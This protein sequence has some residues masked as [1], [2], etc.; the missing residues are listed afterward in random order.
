M[1]IVGSAGSGLGGAGDIGGA[2]GSF[3]SHTIDQSLRF[4]DGDS[5][6]LSRTPSGAGNQKVWTWSAWVKRANITSE[7]TLFGA[8]KGANDYV[9]IQFDANDTLNVT[10]KHVNATGGGLSSQT[11]RKIT[12]QVFRDVS[13]FYHL[14]VKF[15]AGNTNC[16]IYVNGTEVTSFSVNEEPQD[17][18]FEVNAAQ[19]HYIG[20]FQNSV[21]GLAVT[22]FDGYMA[23]INLIDGTALGPDSF[24]ETKDGVWIPKDASGLT[25]GTN[26]F[27]LTFEATGTATTTQD[28][29]AQTNIGDDQSG[30]G[31]NSAVSGLAA[32]D[33]VLDS[34]T[35]NFATMNPLHR[36]NGTT[37]SIT[38]SEGNLAS[39]FAGNHTTM[40]H[41]ATMALPTT[42][43]WY[44]EQTF[45]G[46]LTNGSRAAICGIWN[47][48]AQD[49]GSNNRLTVT[50]DAVTFY[51]DD[52]KIYSSADG[53]IGN[54]SYT[55]SIAEQ[56]GAVV[57]FAVDMDNTWVWVAVN[58]TYINGTPDFSDGTNRVDVVTD[59]NGRYIPFWAGDGGATITWRV[60]FGQDSAN[61]SSAN[62]DSN[63]I[64][65]FEYAVPSGY[66]SLCSANLTEPAII[67]G[68]DYFNTVL[69]SGNGASSRGITGVSHAP[70]FVWIK[71]RNQAN[72]HSLFDSV[73]GVAK[74]LESNSTAVE[75]AN[76]VYGYITSFDSDGFTVGDGSSGAALVNDSGNTF[77]AWNWLAGG[78]ASSNSGGTIT[79]SV[80]ANPEAGF[81]IMT[82]TGNGSSS[83]TVG[84][85]LGA[86]SSPSM[87][88][89]KNRDQGDNWIVRTNATG[90]DK[91]LFLNDVS[92]GGTSSVAL[93]TTD[94]IG[95]GTSGYDNTS[96]EDYVAYLFSNVDGFSK[97]GSYIGNG[98][99]NGTFIHTGFRPAWILVKRTNSSTGAY[100][101]ILDNK[102]NATSGNPVD[103]V[104]MAHATTSEAGLGNV[105]FDF[106]S[107]GFKPRDTTVTV[108]GSASTYIYLAFAEQPFKYANAR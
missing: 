104:L 38:Y 54:V 87:L 4:E 103:E 72:E 71:T 67:S 6:Y 65:T 47:D 92:S 35:N 56:T 43:K 50:S 49:L 46:A 9:A 36:G 12:T 76:N 100:W 8:Y 15:D 41:A 81:S 88:I 97:C 57:S 89:V 3:Y 91:F 80:S 79:S 19:V 61:V 69:W 66:T 31:N 52:N 93:P 13:S 33:V 75:Q 107:N 73:R 105:P 96:G 21:T 68:E 90:E 63:G 40:Q 11:R 101:D 53:S 39:S 30:L 22:Y 26:G 29:T 44:W 78:S 20:T 25:F 2:L 102:R 28:T 48:D 84:H 18:S 94:V 14:V 34:P 55:S 82:Y 70:D 95:L 27:H 7:Q 99:A 83:Q 60:N 16:D 24:G 42:G 74:D 86:V 108:N 45:T 17:L 10:F 106:L 1:S 58:G 5:P 85:G 23:E 51:S 59:T 98:N 32:T 77:V 37:G 64:G 62:S